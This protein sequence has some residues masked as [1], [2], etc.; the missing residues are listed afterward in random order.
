MCLGRIMPDIL[1]CPDGYGY[2]WSRLGLGHAVTDLKNTNKVFYDSTVGQLSWH[3][4]HLFFHFFGPP[5]LPDA[6]FDNS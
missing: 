4:F 6:N 1:A 3:L 2:G 5:H